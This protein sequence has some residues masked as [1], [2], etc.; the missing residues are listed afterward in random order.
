MFA[1]GSTSER[2]RLA[3]S[4]S[5]KGKSDLSKYEKARKLKKCIGKIRGDYEKALEG[6][7]QTLK[8][9]HD[10]AFGMYFAALCYKKMNLLDKFETYYSEY[11]E[12]VKDSKT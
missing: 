10:H 5:F 8:L 1:S 11:K 7:L 12:I 4:S 3:A 6:I 2:M 9:K